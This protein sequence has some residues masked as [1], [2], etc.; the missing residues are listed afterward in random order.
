MKTTKIL[1]GLSIVLLI[2]TLHAETL[3]IRN[4][5]IHTLTVHGVLTNTDILIKDRRIE[6][7]AVNISRQ[8]DK[9]ID[10]KGMIITPGIM[11]M[12]TEIGVVEIDAI[13]S[14]VD[15]ETKDI[16]YSAS[17]GLAKIF[18][19]NSTL[20]PEN[21]RGGVTRALVRPGAMHHV[22]AGQASVMSLSGRADSLI[23]DPV[24]VYAVFGERGADLSG[25][26]RA[27]ALLRIEQA[28]KD[29]REYQANVGAIK[30]GEW[31]ELG[32]P[33]NDL[34]ALIPIIKRQ[35]PLV[36]RAHRASDILTLINLADREKIHLVI[37]GAA[38]AWMVADKLV[39]AN[40]P[41]IIDP[42][43]NLPEAFERLGSRLDNA[44][45][46]HKSGVRLIFSG[47]GSHNAYLVRQSAGKAVANGLPHEVALKAMITHPA[48]VFGV[49]GDY[50]RIEKGAL[51][52]FVV[53][54]G[55]PLEVTTNVEH[56]IIDGKLYAPVSRSTRLRDRY[57]DLSK[58]KQGP[59]YIR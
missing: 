36:V 1:L 42:I 52:E 34:V 32:L 19:P 56:I 46:L 37:D 22:F 24:A 16:H 11:A 53:W 23:A 9:V 45:R 28:L 2:G 20:I 27:S 3:L 6:T 15:S 17:F 40:V 49:A 39:E 26:S 54:D 18:N 29:T 12:N 43:E 10:A 8:A 7:V 50:G 4:A 59:A 57:K 31:R 21:R 14:T 44:A 38:E 48:E 35:Q 25:G 41:V 13:D 33:I 58:N 55:D 51:A 5:K 30:K 47:P